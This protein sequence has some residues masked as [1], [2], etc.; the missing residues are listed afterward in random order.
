MTKPKIEFHSRGPSGNIFYLLGMCRDVLRK[1]HRI[2]DYNTMWEE[3][4]KGDYANAIRVIREYIDLV[5]LDGI[6][7]K[8]H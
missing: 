3:V 6:Y 7:Q 5:D 2:T 4:Q 8:R 1:Q